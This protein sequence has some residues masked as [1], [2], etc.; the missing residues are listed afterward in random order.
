MRAGLQHRVHARTS[1]STGGERKHRQRQ[2]QSFHFGSFPVG[3]GRM[4]IEERRWP[5]DRAACQATGG[6]YECFTQ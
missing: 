6:R 4:A 2:E 5:Q 3:D 1:I